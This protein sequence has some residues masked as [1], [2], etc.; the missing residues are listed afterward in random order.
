MSEENQK[1]APQNVSDLIAAG[2]S[3]VLSLIPLT[4]PIGAVGSFGLLVWQRE[5]QQKFIFECQRRFDTLDKS[6]LDRSALE[7]D[8]FKVL[9]VQ[10]VETAARTASGLK[11]QAL[12]SAL[13]SSV[14]LPTSR[15][16]GKQALL[17]LLEQISDEEMVALKVL[18]DEELPLEEI[19][20]K[21]AIPTGELPRV[22]LGMKEADVAARLGWSE[23]D[24]L[25]ACQGLRQLGLVHEPDPDMS[26]VITDNNAPEERGWR[27]TAIAEKLIKW[28]G[29]T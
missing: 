8:E 15:F 2:V 28:C 1:N 7:S 26:Y 21:S 17:R 11:R 23:E 3:S 20:P 12:A 9:V 25:I 10:A 6:K 29:E 24:A 27:V 16:T 14:V 5:Q 4:A 19:R 18:C 22:R 13:V